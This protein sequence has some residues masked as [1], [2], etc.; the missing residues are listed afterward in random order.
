MAYQNI[1]NI[2]SYSLTGRSPLY[3][4]EEFFEHQDTELLLG[5]K[6]DPLQF[7]DYTV[8]RV[9]DRIYD[10]GTMKLFSQ[11]AMQALTTFRIDRRHL[12]FDTT[13][14]SVQ[15]D[16][17]LYSKENGNDDVMKIVHGHSKDHRPDLKQF[18][19]KMLCVDR[20]IPVFG[21]A[22]DGNA[23]DKIVNTALNRTSAF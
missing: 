23:S 3:R 4:L 15:G 8:G 9:L 10:Y 18:M 16:Y 1:V 19:V 22:E 5:K 14:V 7:S 12:S 13:S 21:A 20:T 17:A 11:I 2:E 6:T